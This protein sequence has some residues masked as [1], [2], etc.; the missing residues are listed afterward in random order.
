VAGIA[1]PELPRAFGLGPGDLIGRGGQSDVYA[2]DAGRILRVLRSPAADL[3]PLHR[4]QTLL[5]E[6]DGRLAIPT[7]TIAEIDGEGRYTIE[8]RLPGHSMLDLLPSLSGAAR[9]RAF[10]NFTLGAEAPAAIAF[11]DRAYGEVLCDAPIRAEDWHGYLRASL[12]RYAEANRSAIAAEAGDPEALKAKALALLAGVPREPPKALVHGD[13]FPGNVLLDSGQRLSG[14]VDFS[15]WTVVGDR[16]IDLSGAAIFL[17]M[18]VEAEPGDI[19]LVRRL[20]L[21]RHGAALEAAGPFYRAYFAFAMAD[22]GNY[23]GLYPKLFPWSIAN[24]KALDAG[25]IAF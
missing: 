4:L 22:P 3:A 23:G 19:A 10:R 11:A 21:H 5:S 16:A 8:R 9:E 17:E 18:I 1:G 14:L 20:L 7:A 12:E 15:I 6:I 25:R 24:L 2:L 13:Y